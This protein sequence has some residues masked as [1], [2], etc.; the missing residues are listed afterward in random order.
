MTNRHYLQSLKTCSLTKPSIFDWNI[1]NFLLNQLKQST[2]TPFFVLHESNR[3]SAHRPSSTRQPADAIALP[4]SP[5][6]S[7]TS[8]SKPPV[9][10]A[11]LATIGIANWHRVYNGICTRPFNFVDVNPKRIDCEENQNCDD[12]NVFALA[13]RDVTRFDSV[14]ELFSSFFSSVD[15]HC[16]QMKLMSNGLFIA[17]NQQQSTFVA[18]ELFSVR[19]RSSRWAVLMD[20]TDWHGA[21]IQSL[22]AFQILPFC[23][24]FLRDN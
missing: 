12:V 6:N 10:V 16:V 18:D 20:A 21:E 7:L 11:L 13:G 8:M 4:Q 22:F 9:I 1:P 19:R 15:H 17:L 3:P 23:V 5:V 24:T 2:L 14:S